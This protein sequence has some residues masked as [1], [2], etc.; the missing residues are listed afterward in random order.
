MLLR[1][2][3]TGMNYWN[4][5]TKPYSRVSNTIIGG[6]RH[7][8]VQIVMHK[9]M[10]VTLYVVCVT[11]KPF[12]EALTQFTHSPRLTAEDAVWGDRLHVGFSS[13][14]VIRK[15]IFK[16]MKKISSSS[17]KKATKS[18]L[19]LHNIC[20]NTD[21]VQ[22]INKESHTK[23]QMETKFG[24]TLCDWRQTWCITQIITLFQPVFSHSN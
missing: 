18:A 14:A 8:R 4:T 16:I 5:D 22:H 11:N 24:D 3:V 13:T 6:G 12:I 7:R 17:G 1:L 23:V 15:S 20:I 19:E 10:T 9:L 21:Q 2:W